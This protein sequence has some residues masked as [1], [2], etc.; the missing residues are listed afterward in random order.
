ML[1]TISV[2]NKKTKVSVVVFELLIILFVCISGI[3][4]TQTM[5]TIS[6]VI[7]LIALFAVINFI[8][9]KIAKRDEDVPIYIL[10]LF[11]SVF[12]S[13][14]IFSDS[15][16]SGHDILFHVIRI[17][18]IRNNLSQGHIITKLQ[19]D[20]YNGYGYIVG[21]FYGQALLY[22]PAVFNLAGFPME[23]AFKIFVFIVNVAS[24]F[25]SYGCFKQFFG[26]KIGLLSA[27]LYTLSIYRLVNIFLRA[28]VGEYTAMLFLPVIACGLYKLIKQ[29]KEK[30]AFVLI[31]VSIPALINSHIL[32]TEISAF[33]C[34]L[35]CFLFV[36]TFAK[37]KNVCALACSIFGGIILAL[38]FIVPFVD[39]YF[40]GNIRI[41]DNARNKFSLHDRGVF[42]VQLFD[43]LPNGYGINLSIDEGIVGEMPLTVGVALLVGLAI[44]IIVLALPSHVKG[45]DKYYDKK[46]LALYI[47]LSLLSIY[48]TT[49]YFPWNMFENIQ[50]IDNAIS[51]IQFP[52]RFLG[53]ASLFI[54]LAIG[55]SLC[56]IIESKYE[57]YRLFPEII[58]LGLCIISSSYFLDDSLKH[59][60]LAAY[61]RLEDIKHI[62]PSGEYNISG[63]NVELLDHTYH[64]SGKGEIT[65][66]S[67]A[68][69]A[70]SFHISSENGCVIDL[71]VFNY[72]YY[73]AHLYSEPNG[74]SELE[75][76]NGDNNEI[77]LVI[78]E[79]SYGNVRVV[80]RMPGLWYF[81]YIVSAI[82]W[83]LFLFYIIY[84]MMNKRK[85]I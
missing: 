31:T 62:Y 28:A 41:A 57:K 39:M 77:E 40:T 51:S 9:V 52:W 78:P 12:A 21:A 20:W 19:P 17:F 45:N 16:L 7:I 29:D 80:Y 68:D 76:V 74:V 44:S 2:N 11:V 18:E 65:E 24:A 61:D 34:A 70:V 33:Y 85:R 23:I 67:K 38:N 54:C 75:I 43:L 1:E 15:A 63:T 6:R 72:K 30:I 3:S 48:M 27:T 83:I 73:R 49:V 58:V 35:I 8:S 84:L 69:N 47:I 46:E 50:G 56:M 5:V 79:Q 25:I 59:R 22:I 55:K 64:I 36:E 14:P 32:S 37:K 10:L 82:S 4:N 66:Y 71:P 26:R 13:Y 81:S 53:P 42:I 60:E